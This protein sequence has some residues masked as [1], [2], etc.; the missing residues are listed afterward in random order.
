MIDV[1]QQMMAH[2]LLV[3]DGRPSGAAPAATSP[4]SASRFR[5][6][7]DDSRPAPGGPT[8]CARDSARRA[9]RR[10]TAQSPRFS[11]ARIIAVEMLRGP[12]HIA[13]RN[14]LGHAVASTRGARVAVAGSRVQSL[15]PLDHRSTTAVADRASIDRPHRHDAGEGAGHER[16]VGAVD[17]GQAERRLAGRDAVVAADREH[18]A[19][20]DPGEAVVAGRGPAPRPSRPATMKKCVEL[21]VATKPCGSSISASSAPA[22]YAWMQAVMSLSLVWVLS[23]GSCTSGWPRRT[24]TVNSVMPSFSVVG[25]RLLVLGDDHHRRRPDRHARILIGRAL[26][27]ARDHQPHVHAV[28]HVVGPERRVDRLDQL[29]AA[30]ADVERDRLRALVQ[31]VEMLARGRPGGPAQRAGPPTRRRRARSPSRTPTRPPARAARARR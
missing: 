3:P 23:L 29:I 14:D 10:A 4:R 1:R 25:Q 7:R 8:R 15:E 5:L 19:A 6:V 28:A 13:I 21:Q 24:C 31:T 20:R 11:H 16:F 26:D 18:V 22:V 30:E 27:A 12:D 17:V 9:A 2:M